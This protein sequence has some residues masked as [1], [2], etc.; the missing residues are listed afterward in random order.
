MKL[1]KL[2]HKWLSVLVALQ[3]LIWLGS[4]LFF[5]L[6]DHNKARGNE[7]RI[8]AEQ[9]TQV[10]PSRLF[11]LNSLLAQQQRVNSIKLVSLLSKPYY[12]L[13]HEQALYPHFYNEHSLFNAYTGEQQVIDKAMAKALASSTYKGKAAVKS[14]TKASPPIADF[15][16][17]QNTVWQVNFADELN[18]SVYIDA[19]SGRVVGHSN[20]HKRFA[21]FFFMLH[22]M[23]YGTVGS[24]N[25]WQII[26]FA[27]LTL[28]FCLTGA[29]WVIELLGRGRY[30]R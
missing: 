13:N 28:V 8:K 17:E 15:P 10:E 20:T 5:N 29:F 22:F 16:K 30:K 6:M 23:D 11:E 25:N 2:M 14:A 19:S 12:L 26:F 3:L 18:T 21:D 7:Y 27:L 9:V 4:G 24:F 1:V